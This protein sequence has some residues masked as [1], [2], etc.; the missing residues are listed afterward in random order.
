MASQSVVSLGASAPPWTPAENGGPSGSKF[1]AG[2]VANGQTPNMRFD[3][4]KTIYLE[5][6][7]TAGGTATLAIDG[8]LDGTHY[9]VLPVQRVDGQTSYTQVISIPVTANMRQIWQVLVP[10]PLLSAIV[11]AYAASANINANFYALP[12]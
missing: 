5:I 7:E 3:G 2:I 1:F 6:F 4:W 11:S 8:T 10:Y 12:V 9:S